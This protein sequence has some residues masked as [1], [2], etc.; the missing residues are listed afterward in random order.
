MSK[1]R[2]PNYFSADE[3]FTKLAA[4]FPKKGGKD[5][6][7]EKDGPERFESLELEE[8]EELLVKDISTI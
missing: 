7:T 4:R 2:H 1:V 6:W 3:Q 5:L 8:E